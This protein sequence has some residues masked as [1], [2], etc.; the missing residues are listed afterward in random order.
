MSTRIDCPDGY[1]TFDIQ[2][3][4]LTEK[5][6][7]FDYDH[8]LVKPNHGTFSRNA[9]DWVW[10]RENIPSILKNLHK[11]GYSIVIF[12]NQTKNYKIK[13]IKNVL[14]TLEIPIRVWIAIDKNLQ[15]PSPFMWN[16]L[17]VS[18]TINKTKSFFVGDAL[19]RTGDWSNT[20]KLFAD[21]CEIQI[22]SPEECFPFEKKQYSEFIPSKTQELVL[23]MGFPGS[24]KT[25]Y[26]KN[27]IPD[28]YTKLHGDILKT[29]AK[30]KKAL[31][32]ALESKKSVVLDATHPNKEKRKTFIE[33]AKDYNV[34]VRLIHISTDFDESKS[35][36]ENR[37]QK[38]PIIVLYVYRKNYEEPELSEGYSD[39]IT[40]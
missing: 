24:G 23:M 9:D 1:I 22:K 34:P 19:G 33:I 4:N 6:A 16:K 26:V 13:Q 3:F 35:R 10:L 8:T 32:I 20:D 28:T 25:T 27:C 7:S 38:V 17:N 5:V 30:K 2:E 36:N 12:T 18:Q 40:V 21:N 11:E 29:N 37:E 39:V 15:K 31:K 14:E